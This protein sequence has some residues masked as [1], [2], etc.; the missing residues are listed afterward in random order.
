MPNSTAELAVPQASLWS[1]VKGVG[2]MLAPIGVLTAAALQAGG[3]PQPLLAGGIATIAFLALG[4]LH[5]VGPSRASSHKSASPVY[6]V[7]VLILWLT[8]KNHDDRFIQ[9]SLSILVGIPLILFVFQE[10]I[11]TGGG[12]LRRARS[13]VRRIERKQDWPEDL[14]ACKLL[15]EVKALREAL[16]EDAEP[17]LCLLAHP[18]ATVRIAALATLEYRP[19]WRKGQAENVLQAAKYAKE[20]PVRAAAMM[21]LANVDDPK[22]ASTIAAYLRDASGEVR[23]AAAESLLWDTERR[24]SHIRREIRAAMSDSHCR[25]DGPLPIPGTIPSQALLDLMMWSGES[26]N[27]GLRA[28]QTVISHYNRELNENQSPELVHS[29]ASRIRDNRMPSSLRVELAHLLAERDCIDRKIWLSWI[30]PSQP[31]ALRLLAAGALL[32][33]AHDDKALETLREVARVPNREMALQVA[34]IIQK[35]LRVDLGLP[36]SGAAPEPQSKLAAEVARRVIEWAD[37]KA[38]PMGDQNSRRTRISAIV[39]QIPR[40][41]GET[42]RRRT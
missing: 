41:T 13:L 37:G 38:K 29:L 25:D 22:L 20:P 15:P 23:R 39:R 21:A 14:A 31:S 35:Y 8:A 4:L 26:G 18:E 12:S 40:P 27:M 17:V 34:A 7:T 24:W 6:L 16:H 33:N 28:T 19:A 30:D 36:L 2:V 42:P 5:Q 10:L 11:F 3:S 1:I 32:R 9:I